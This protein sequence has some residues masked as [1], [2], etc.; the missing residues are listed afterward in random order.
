MCS[1]QKWKQFF[2]ISENS[3]TGGGMNLKIKLFPES[4][5]L[6][7]KPERLLKTN[8]VTFR[9][10]FRY[11]GTECDEDMERIEKVLRKKTEMKKQTAI[12]D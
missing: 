2:F 12:T 10:Y 1:R 9:A 4:Y 5:E 3:E 7:G 8:L 6:C 11:E